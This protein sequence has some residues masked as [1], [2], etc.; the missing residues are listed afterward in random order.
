MLVFTSVF[1]LDREG[2]T[3]E[4]VEAAPESDSKEIELLELKDAVRRRVAELK[5]PQRPRKTAGKEEN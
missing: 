4:P 2:V 1:V 3:F 5:A